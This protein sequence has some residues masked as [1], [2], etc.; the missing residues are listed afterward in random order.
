MIWLVSSFFLDAIQRLFGVRA[1]LWGVHCDCLNP[2]AYAFYDV[3]LR[4][5]PV[6]TS[7]RWHVG[8]SPAARDLVDF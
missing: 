3:L 1:W 7:L 6:N 8:L 5:A 2:D 4:N